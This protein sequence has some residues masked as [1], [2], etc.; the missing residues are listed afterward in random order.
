MTEDFII[1][2]NCRSLYGR[3]TGAIE[4]STPESPVPC[5]LPSSQTLPSTVRFEDL[6]ELNFEFWFVS[7][8]LVICSKS[9]VAASRRLS[10]EFDEESDVWPELSDWN[11]PKNEFF[12]YG[13]EEA[14]WVEQC[15]LWIGFAFFISYV[16]FPDIFF[17][18]CLIQLLCV[19]IS[20]R[21]FGKFRI[22]IITMIEA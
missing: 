11:N 19:S 15:D 16:Q 14:N 9:L 17:I 12:I 2:S 1:S 8:S 3:S 10:F 18:Q 5:K 20:L 22:L 6:S 4:L 13:S 7:I 21:L